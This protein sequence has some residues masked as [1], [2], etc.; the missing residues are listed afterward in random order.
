MLV[1]RLFFSV[2]DL[3]RGD[4]VTIREFGRTI[5][6][7]IVGLPGERISAAG[8]SA[9]VNG[10]TIPEPWLRNIT[11]TCVDTHKSSVSMVL[12]SGEYFVMGDCRSLSTD[13]RAFGPVSE[14]LITGRVWSVIAKSGHPWFS[15]VH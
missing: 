13:S 15:F 12:T 1:Q 5:V 3:H 10:R 8:D 6:K 14:T 4:L 11:N 9:E 7:R 2:A